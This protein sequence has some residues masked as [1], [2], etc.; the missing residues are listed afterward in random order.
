MNKTRFP[1]LV[2]VVAIFCQLFAHISAGGLRSDSYE[3]LAN[4][5]TTSSCSYDTTCM[6]GGYEGV[7]VSIS[8][9]CCTSGVATSGLCPGSSDIQCCT[10]SKCSTPSGS[11]TCM[12]SSLCSSKG[13]TSVSG[14][15][16]GPS[17]LQCCVN[18]PTPPSGVYG[19]DVCDTVTPTAASCFKSAGINYIIPRGYRSTGVVDTQVCTSMINA[20]NAGIATRDTYMFPCEFLTI[21]PLF[22]F[23]CDVPLFY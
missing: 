8:S 10:Q 16:T 2:V 14:L 13:G 15:C 21:L 9:G 12:Q 3:I 11:G 4:N 22:D 17:D 1:C 5:F 6:S 19:V 20:Y 18:N 7:C 23:L